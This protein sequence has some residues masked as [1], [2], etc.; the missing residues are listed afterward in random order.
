MI[1][2]AGYPIGQDEP[3]GVI[4]LDDSQ[5][6]AWASGDNEMTLLYDPQSGNTRTVSFAPGYLKLEKTNETEVRLY[7]YGAQPADV[8]LSVQGSL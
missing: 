3:L 4:N 1:S 7:N 2:N 6:I 8:M 5:P